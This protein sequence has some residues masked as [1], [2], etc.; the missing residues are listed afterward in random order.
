MNILNALKA[1]KYD[2]HDH[3][4]NTSLNKNTLPRFSLFNTYSSWL[5][6]YPSGPLVCCCFKFPGY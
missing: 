5:H 2:H 3:L 4:R 1:E 6:L